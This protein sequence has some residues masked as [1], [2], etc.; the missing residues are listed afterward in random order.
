[1]AFGASPLT[2]FASLS[3]FALRLK[4]RKT[5]NTARRKKGKPKLC[6]YCLTGPK[7]PCGKT[8]GYPARFALLFV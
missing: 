3:C 2:A 4:P 6:G 1:R 5:G 8:A 7:P